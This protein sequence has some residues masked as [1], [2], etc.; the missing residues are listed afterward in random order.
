M[1]SK[2]ILD[3]SVANQQRYGGREFQ[4]GPTREGP[5]LFQGLAICGRCSCGMTVRYHLRQGRLRPDYLCQLECIER[6]TPICQ[7]LPGAGI[8]ATIGEVVVKSVTPLALEAALEVQ[9]EIQ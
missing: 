2:A 3:T 8:D 1:F 6:G 5:A 4:S 7:Q 9:Q